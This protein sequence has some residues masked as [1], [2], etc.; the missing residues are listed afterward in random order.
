V[1]ASRDAALVDEVNDAYRRS[2]LQEDDM[3][4]VLH[5]LG[6]ALSKNATWEVRCNAAK[7]AAV[8]G[9][10][11]ALR[12]L[13]KVAAEGDE[14]AVVASTHALS[15]ASLSAL[16]ERAPAAA[17]AD[18]ASRLR[19][20]LS[21]DSFELPHHAAYCASRLA[22]SEANAD[23]AVLR[24]LRAVSMVLLR[25]AEDA[26]DLVLDAGDEAACT[27]AYERYRA[28]QCAHEHF[29]ANALGLLGFVLRLHKSVTA[30][31]RDSWP[32]D[33][34]IGHAAAAILRGFRLHPI[35]AGAPLVEP[36]SVPWP[37]VVRALRVFVAYSVLV[38]LPFHLV[39]F[40]LTWRMRYRSRAPSVA[41]YY[42]VLGYAN[43]FVHLTGHL[44]GDLCILY[45]AG[46]APEWPVGP[47]TLL[48]SFFLLWVWRKALL[49][50]T[51]TRVSMLWCV[52]CFMG[53]LL[54]VAGPVVVLGNAAHV[55]NVAA[56][57]WTAM[58]AG[59]R[60]RAMRRTFVATTTRGAKAKQA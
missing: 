1:V 47:P 46:A 26:V 60:E 22:E 58:R 37:V 8:L 27:E 28:L 24:L 54:V 23:P 6:D 29:V 33:A 40:F 56:V 53:P 34:E 13:C 52:V 9:W 15:A 2:A 44:I 21:D 36:R 7:A 19:S 49:P 25:D 59:E 31:G 12:E 57:I 17:W 48:H 14:L 5:I 41:V 35:A 10:G 20:A 39:A 42:A 18:A 3:Q 16:R 45:A 32:S 51:L 38:L 11:A 55:V 30:L 43:A 50:P 4:A